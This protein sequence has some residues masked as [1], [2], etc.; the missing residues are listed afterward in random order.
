MGHF[1]AR[2]ANIPDYIHSDTVDNVPQL[3]D[4]SGTLTN[5]CEPKSSLDNVYNQQGQF[6]LDFC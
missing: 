6:L 4:H 1:Y 5:N 3:L 2:T